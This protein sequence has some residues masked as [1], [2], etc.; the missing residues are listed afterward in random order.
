MQEILQLVYSST[1]QMP[2]HFCSDG[3]RGQTFFIDSELLDTKSEQAMAAQAWGMAGDESFGFPKGGIPEMDSATL[4]GI[5]LIGENI[6][7]ASFFASK[8][9]KLHLMDSITKEI[10][11]NAREDFGKVPHFL[12]LLDI[13]CVQNYFEYC[14]E[15][16]RKI[17][18]ESMTGK[19]FTCCFCSKEFDGYGNNPS[20]VRDVSEECCDDC[21]QN[22]VIPARRISPFYTK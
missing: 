1:R 10:L 6:M 13:A 14:S 9:E 4:G 17:A 8:L 18:L 22:I 2:A 16:G 19:K 5:V 7:L 11:E 15:F 20:P 3:D 21:N 12:P